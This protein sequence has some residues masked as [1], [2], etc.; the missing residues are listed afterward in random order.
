MDFRILDFDPEHLRTGEWSL[1]IRIGSNNFEQKIM[2]AP[3]SAVTKRCVHNQIP[4]EH[5]QLDQDR[6]LPPNTPEHSLQAE[7]E[8]E[9]AILG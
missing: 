4:P 5:G 6:T 9:R 3:K 8:E 7:H 2:H 1:S